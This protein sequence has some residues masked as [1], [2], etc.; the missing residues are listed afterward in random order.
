MYQLYGPFGN[1]TLTPE[2]NATAEAGF[3][4]KLFNEKLTVNA[5]GFYRQEQNTF[6]FFFDAV[7]FD[8]FYINNEGKNNAKGVETNVNLEVNKSINFA[9]NYTFTEVEQQFNRFIPKNKVNANANFKITEKLG[10]S[11]IYQYVSDRSDAFYD[12]ANFVTETVNLKAYQLFN[13]NIRYQV[14]P[15]RL[16][17]FGAID[18]IF[19]E[20]FQEVIGYNTRGRNFRIGMNFQ[21]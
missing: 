9:A 8:S 4:T 12:E 2:E 11:L 15:N 20:E 18:N 10:T 5:V 13:A 14:I 21:F 6:G 7:T 1:T 17:L 16:S 19:N 3:E